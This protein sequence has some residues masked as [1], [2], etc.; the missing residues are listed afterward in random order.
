MSHLPERLCLQPSPNPQRKKRKRKVLILRSFMQKHRLYPCKN[1]RIHLKQNVHQKQQRSLS[2][3]A[4]RVEALILKKHAQVLNYGF[5][6]Q[7]NFDNAIVIEYCTNSYFKKQVT[8]NS[9]SQLLMTSIELFL[10][11][12]TLKKPQ[13]DTISF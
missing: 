4:W 6:R 11:N 8:K 12:L 5:N 9:T 3:P 1:T 13:M 2:V 10:S 7:V